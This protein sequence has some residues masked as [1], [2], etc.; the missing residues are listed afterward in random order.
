MINVDASKIGSIQPR[1]YKPELFI[2]E[3]SG[4]AVNINI[5]FLYSQRESMGNQCFQSL[6]E[7]YLCCT[8]I[9]PHPHIH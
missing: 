4:K 2:Q 7:K 6:I 8:I 9:T 1:I 5:Y 3:D